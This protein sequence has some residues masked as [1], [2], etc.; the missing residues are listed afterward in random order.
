MIN[1]Y[2]HFSNSFFRIIQNRCFCMCFSDDF[3]I[4]ESVQEDNWDCESVLSLRSNTT[5]HPGKVNRLTVAGPKKAKK[6]KG[7]VLA[8]IDED[9]EV[10]LPEIECEKNVF[11]VPR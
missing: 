11:K 8:P 3:E 9:D 2:F 7:A 6:K 10:I 1:L 4:V 5:N